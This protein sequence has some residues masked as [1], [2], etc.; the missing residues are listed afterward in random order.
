VIWLV[1]AAAV[2]LAIAAAIDLARPARDQTHLGR[3][4]SNARERG[5]SE[6]TGVI[7]RK[8]S[9]NL[10][11]W[12]TSDWRVMFVIGVLFVGYLAWRGR[13]RVGA[14]VNQVPELRAALIGFAVL[15]VLGY[16]VNDSGVAIPAV[17]LYVLVAALV[18]MLVRAGGA[19]G[20]GASP[21]DPTGA[22]N[23]AAGDDQ[24][25]P[26]TDD[27]TDSVREATPS[28]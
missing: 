13:A 20:A 26:T 4:L 16:A 19:P 2:A 6:I 24:G 3:L 15:A 1:G 25:S 23:D 11:T 14:L 9:H 17:M 8:L 7:S 5:L 27:S 28:H 12:S 21:D 22:A 10:D 18:G